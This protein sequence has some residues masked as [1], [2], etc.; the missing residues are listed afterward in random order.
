MCNAERRAACTAVMR[1]PHKGEAQ[2]SDLECVEYMLEYLLE[3]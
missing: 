1:R 2:W 3:L